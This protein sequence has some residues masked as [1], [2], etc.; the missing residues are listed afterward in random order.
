MKFTVPDI[1]KED[2]REYKIED[3][4]TNITVVGHKRSCFF[5]KY[6]SDVIYDC[7][8]GPYGFCCE[9]K[10]CCKEALYGKCKNF[11]EEK[12]E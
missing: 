10:C 11:E 5:C 3:C 8:I 12:G 4:L 7:I 6:L 1:K 2:K 9:K